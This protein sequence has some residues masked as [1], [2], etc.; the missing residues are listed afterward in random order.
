MPGWHPLIV[1][2]PIAQLTF[3][4]IVD[5]A[6]LLA[7]R[8]A[9]HP[10]AYALLVAG[11]VAAT[12]A[13]ISGNAAAAPYREIEVIGELVGQH[14]DSGSLVLVLYLIVTLGRLPLQLRPP[15]SS[16]PLRSWLIVAAA[17][18]VLLWRA[19]ALGGSLVFE[20]GVG[21]AR[22]VAQRRGQGIA[23]QTDTSQVIIPPPSWSGP[24]SP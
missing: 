20:H 15:T 9:W 6:A 11:T 14:E 21:V 19:S 1:H 13:V 10:V 24:A 22:G 8:P 5:L 23:D 17:G 18:C 16:W 12:A 3:S 2:F 7:K 4:L